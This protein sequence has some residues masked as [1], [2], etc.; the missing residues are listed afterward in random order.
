MRAIGKML[1]FMGLTIP[2]LAIMLQLF[3]PFGTR[4]MLIALCFSLAAFYLGRTIEGYAA[5]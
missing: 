5:R 1:Q 4:D 2:I 3:G